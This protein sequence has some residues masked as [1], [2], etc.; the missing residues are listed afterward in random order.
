MI[1]IPCE[2]AMSVIMSVKI[3]PQMTYRISPNTD[4]DN[5]SPVRICILVF[6][7]LACCKPFLSVYFLSA[8]FSLSISCKFAPFI[9]LSGLSNGGSGGNFD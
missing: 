5:T 1:L 8:C 6:V 7:V 3:P 9:S 4:G 2:C